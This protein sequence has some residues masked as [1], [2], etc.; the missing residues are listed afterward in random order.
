MIVAVTGEIPI[1][2]GRRIAIVPT[3][4]IPGRTPINVPRNT[5]T[6]QKKRFVRLKQT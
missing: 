4:P 2:I 5:P 1:V 3:G 6:R